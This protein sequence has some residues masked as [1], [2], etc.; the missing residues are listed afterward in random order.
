[1]K[2]SV[3]ITKGKQMVGFILFQIN[4]RKYETYRCQTF[5]KPI[6][7]ELLNLKNVC[8]INCLGRFIHKGNDY[9]IQI[10]EIRVGVEYVD[11]PLDRKSVV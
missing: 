1:M 7:Q 11:I 5:S 3:F 2:P 4:Q 9:L 6:I 8:E 10:E